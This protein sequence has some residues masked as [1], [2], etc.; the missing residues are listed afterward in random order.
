MVDEYQRMREKDEM[1]V[2]IILVGADRSEEDLIS[3][4]EKYGMKWA[5]VEY[6]S[7]GMLEGY[8]SEGIPHFVLVERETGKAIVHGTGPGE[9]EKA[10]A[11]M[12]KYSGV[13]G[14]FEIGTWMDRYGL[15]AA[16]FVAGIGI[17]LLKHLRERR[18]RE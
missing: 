4:M 1:P 3:Y 16:V 7:E 2:Q 10:V 18:A 11:E 5:A 9:I 17:L 13:S 6:G 12:R 8:A 15:L 14:D